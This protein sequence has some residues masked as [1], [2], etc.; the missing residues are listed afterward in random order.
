MSSKEVETLISS[1][2]IDVSAEEDVFKFILAWIEH[3]KSKR[4]KYFAEL[5][6]HV[7]L[8]YVSRDFLSRDVVTNDLVKD[9]EVCLDLVKDAMN[10]IDFRSYHSSYSFFRPKLVVRPRKSLETAAIVFMNSAKNHILG[11]FPREDKLCILGELSSL[12]SLECQPSYISELFTTLVSCHGKLFIAQPFLDEL[13]C[14]DPFTSTWRWPSTDKRQL[15]QIFVS[16]KNEMYALM[17]DS[18]IDTLYIRK[19]KPE[20]NSWE[21]DVPFKCGGASLWLRKGMCI[22]AKDSFIYFIGGNFAGSLEGLKDVYRYDLNKDEVNKLADLQVERNY[23]YG[24]SA[25]GKIFVAGGKN[26]YRSWSKTCEVYDETTNEWYFIAGWR[27]P[28]DARPKILSADDKLY[29]VFCLHE[30]DSPETRI[31]CYDPEKDE[32]NEAAEIPLRVDAD[33]ARNRLFDYPFGVNACSMRVFKGL[34][35]NGSFQEAS[36]SPNHPGKLKLKHMS[37]ADESV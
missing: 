2:E 10:L 18:G 22:V 25:H 16:N 7:R 34:L 9:N 17:T 19:Y 6:R 15:Q 33:G 36:V 23:A 27:M 12:E 8:V 24:A 29:S 32:W 1:D 37:Y 13:L 11:Y 28:L 4:K 35:S 3:D 26:E 31:E 14:Y 21:A 30:S 5:F 20:S